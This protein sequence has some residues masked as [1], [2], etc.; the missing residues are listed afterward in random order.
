VL[1]TDRDGAVSVFM[2]PD[3]AKIRR[4]REQVRRYWNG[5]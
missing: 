5:R 4:E 1:R 3:G 2:A